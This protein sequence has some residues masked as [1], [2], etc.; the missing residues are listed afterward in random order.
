ML[1]WCCPYE[2]HH[3]SQH[4]HNICG[5]AKDGVAVR[6]AETWRVDWAS[7][8]VTFEGEQVRVLLSRAHLAEVLKGLEAGGL[9]HVA[10]QLGGRRQAGQAKQDLGTMR[11][12]LGRK[13]HNGPPRPGGTSPT[14]L[15]PRPGCA[16]VY[17]IMMQ[18]PLKLLAAQKN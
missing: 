6:Q 13:E 7:G 5:V 1:K 2:Q 14:P 8:W 17:S 4:A 9:R 18:E 3:F 11:A 16:Q 12:V 10:V 15:Q